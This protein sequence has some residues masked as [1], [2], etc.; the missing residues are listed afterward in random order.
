MT[1]A[2]TIKLISY[3]AAKRAAGAL[4]FDLVQ[5][6]YY[7]PI[8]GHLPESVWEERNPLR[9]IRWDL[10]S[11]LE[12]LGQ[13]DPFMTEF[14]PPIRL[15]ETYE[16][17]YA[18]GSFGNGDADVLYGVIRAGKPKR[19]LELGSGHSSVVIHLA[20][21]RND[22]DGSPCEH[23]IFD[24]HPTDHL[25]TLDITP[26][27]AEMLPEEEIANLSAGDILFVDTTHAV[28]IG[29]D[30]LR[31]VL[32]LLPM[33]NPGVLIH[34]HDIFLPY[35]YPRAF[36]EE[37]EYYWAEQ[38]LLQAFLACNSQ[39]EI[40]AP[41]HALFRDRT[42]AFSALVPSISDGGYPGSFWCRRL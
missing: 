34:L 5:Q 40:V 33:T 4:G 8:P 32:D 36:F 25:G 14:S 37:H 38:Y 17:Q 6:H 13:I 28:R 3:R 22:T 24:P 7:S 18:N 29:G 10:D 1:R 23:R 42:Q 9:G 26:M 11:C 21:E 20:T 41:L 15:G 30:V 31:V 27:P 39:F 2:H 16:F 12:W 35:Q 19:I